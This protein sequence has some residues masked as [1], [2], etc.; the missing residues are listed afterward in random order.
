MFRTCRWQVLKGHFNET[1]KIHRLITA[2]PPTDRGNITAN[3]VAV[4]G[5]CLSSST[6]QAALLAADGVGGTA[7]HSW[8]CRIVCVCCTSISSVCKGALCITNPLW[9]HGAEG[10]AELSALIRA[11]CLERQAEPN[12]AESS[13]QAQEQG[14]M[15][16]AAAGPGPLLLWHAGK[17]VNVMSGSRC[18]RAGFSV[19][20]E[21]GMTMCSGRFRR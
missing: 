3:G 4:A 19:G 2:T 21:G 10:G 12:R 14:A 18:H 11:S 5:L 6:L 9:C 13:E 7:L 16:T 1:R 15:C 8:P 20:Q 17:W